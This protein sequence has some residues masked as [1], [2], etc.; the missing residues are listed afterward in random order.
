MP[1]AGGS[2][3]LPRIVG[4]ALA[5]ELIFTSRVLDGHSAKQL[6]KNY[7]KF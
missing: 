7:M 2:Q 4:P 1:G 6:G 5:K 3:L